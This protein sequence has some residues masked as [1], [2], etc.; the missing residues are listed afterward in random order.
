MLCVIKKHN[1]IIIL[2]LLF[3]FML[4]INYIFYYFKKVYKILSK[5]YIYKI[6]SFYLCYFIDN[7]FFSYFGPIYKNSWLSGQFIQGT[8]SFPNNI[9]TNINIKD[10]IGDSLNNMELFLFFNKTSWSFL[11]E[12]NSWI[13]GRFFSPK[14]QFALL[15]PF[16]NVEKNNFFLLKRTVKKKR[17]YYYHLFFLQKFLYIKFLTFTFLLNLI[18]FFFIFFIFKC[19]FLIN[20]LIFSILS[21]SILYVLK[22]IILNEYKQYK[23]GLYLFIFKNY[24]IFSEFDFIPGLEFN[25]TEEQSIVKIYNNF[26]KD[27]NNRF[28]YNL[29]LTKLEKESKFFKFW[30]YVLNNI[31]DLSLSS[32]LKK[33][34]KNFFH[35]YNK[36]KNN[37][38]IMINNFLLNPDKDSEEE[39]IFIEKNQVNLDQKFQSQKLIN[40]FFDYFYRRL[41]K[42]YL[43]QSNYLY[44]CLSLFFKNPIYYFTIHKSKQYLINLSYFFFKKKENKKFNLNFYFIF[45]LINY[46]QSSTFKNIFFINE[47]L[48]INSNITQK[49]IVNFFSEHNKFLNKEFNQIIN[50]NISLNL[51]KK[52]LY[53]ENNIGIIEKV[54]NNIIMTQQYLIYLKYIKENPINIKRLNQQLKKK[55]IFLQ[56]NKLKNNNIN[57]LFFGNKIINE[58]TSQNILFRNLYFFTL[59]KGGACDVKEEVSNPLY[60]R[61]S[62]DNVKVKDFEEQLKKLD[63]GIL[64]KEKY[65]F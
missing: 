58:I 45:N 32:N 57:S 22:L 53:Y 25:K 5:F 4:L 47:I 26:K 18:L 60:S 46:F 40:T 23:L 41:E 65:K 39:H 52:L 3:T 6:F 35:L 29:D 62:S 15:T 2:F 61:Y 43:N 38:N 54:Y 27:F 42:K 7:F 55:Y 33:S 56:N 63:V 19:S 31:H 34:K 16:S 37:H 21:I 36:S 51:Y 12:L 48:I 20:T 50:E 14:V 28:L 11:A 44:F 17:I 49:N 9:K 30:H 13:G 24:E 1:I 64:N 59:Y 10:N 8:P